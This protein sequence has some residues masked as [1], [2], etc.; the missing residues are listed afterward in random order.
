MQ[1]SILCYA[2]PVMASPQGYP[3][4]LASVDDAA[5]SVELRVDASVYPLDALYAASYVFIDR[6]YVFLDRP[7]EGHY[8]VHLSWKKG[9]APGG[10]LRALGGEFM[11]ELLSCAWRAKIAHESRTIIETATTSALAGAMGP[12]SLDDLEKFDFSEEA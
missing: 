3:E 7:D 8:R 2:P 9:E 1:T 12:P 10:A 11:N 5:R 6:C 4:A